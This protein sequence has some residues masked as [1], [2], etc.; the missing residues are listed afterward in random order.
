M[1]PQ[2]NQSFQNI[3]ICLLCSTWNRCTLK[4]LRNT[5]WLAVPLQFWPKLCTS[6]SCRT[7]PCCSCSACSCSSWSRGPSGRPWRRSA[8]EEI[9][10]SRRGRWWLAAGHRRNLQSVFKFKINKLYLLKFYSYYF[11][12]PYLATFF[13][14]FSINVMMAYIPST[15]LGWKSSLLTTSQW[16]LAIL[17]FHFCFLLF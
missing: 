17:R 11:G 13:R 4:H 1:A 9:R 7:G 3:V 6:S 15:T 5:S 14:F 16:L 12:K 8:P 10:T 2:V